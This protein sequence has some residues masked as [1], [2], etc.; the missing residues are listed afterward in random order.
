MSVNLSF[1]WGTHSTKLIS[2]IQPSNLFIYASRSHK[3]KS[4]KKQTFRD[5][6]KGQNF[7]TIINEKSQFNGY[8]NSDFDDFFYSYT[9]WPYMNT[10]NEFDLQFKIFT[11]LDT[12]KSYVMVI[13]EN[14]GFCKRNNMQALSSIGKV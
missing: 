3:L 8:F 12:T 11:L 10:R 9:P 6:V 14:W 13:D 5:Q 1:W 2:M 7:L 4:A